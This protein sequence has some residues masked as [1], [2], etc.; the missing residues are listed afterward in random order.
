[1]EWGRSDVWLPGLGCKGQYGFCLVLTHV[2]PFSLSLS[3]CLSLSTP[4]SLSSSLLSCLLLNIHSYSWN[5]ATKIWG[6]PHHMQ[7]AQCGVSAN[8]PSKI[9]VVSWH[10]CRYKV[11]LQII[12]V[13]SP[14]TILTA[15]RGGEWAVLDKFCLNCRLKNKINVISLLPFGSNFYTA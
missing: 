4:L 8:S 10:C 13:P 1:M 11:G 14:W 12:P 2:H 5:L 6:S 7:R 15:P 9:S 3:L